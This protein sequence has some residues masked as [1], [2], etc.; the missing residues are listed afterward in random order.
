MQVRYRCEDEHNEREER[1][2][3]VNN[4]NRRERLSRRKWQVVIFRVVKQ[5][6]RVV[7]DLDAAAEVILAVAEDTKGDAFV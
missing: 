2:D 1:R 6:R 7:A 3:W 4:Q 5:Y